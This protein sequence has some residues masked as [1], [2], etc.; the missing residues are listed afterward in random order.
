MSKKNIRKIED[1][2]PVKTI[3]KSKNLTF[4]AI[5]IFFVGLFFARLNYIFPYSMYA[6]WIS[7]LG[8][9]ILNPGAIFFSL[10]CIISS[11]ILMIV[12]TRSKNTVIMIF[13]ILMSFALFLVGFY[14]INDPIMHSFGADLFFKCCLICI[15][16]STIAA[17]GFARLFGIF[18][19]LITL[20]FL[21]V[22][23][24]PFVEWVTFLCDFTYISMICYNY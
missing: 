8:N 22:A 1:T 9:S 18:C 2:D 15:A 5:A 17:K 16:L 23:F 20:V 4:L 24:Q 11:I 21:C 13:G 14:P 3:N 6:N 7:D 10:G 19:T 12:F